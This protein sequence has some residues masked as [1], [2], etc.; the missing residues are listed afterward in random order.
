MK[1][2]FLSLLSVK[3][4]SFQ[5]VYPVREK[6]FSLIESLGFFFEAEDLKCNGDEY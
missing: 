6:G 3:G 1:S 5:I 4:I 2:F